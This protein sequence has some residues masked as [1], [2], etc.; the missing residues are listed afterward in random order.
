MKKLNSILLVAAIITFI[1]CL[2][3][4]VDRNKTIENSH[5]VRYIAAEGGYIDG[6]TEQLVEDGGSS[7]VVIAR[8]NSGYEFAGW[9][10]GVS[11]AGRRELYVHNNITV[12]AYFT[13]TG[14]TTDPNDPSDPSTEAPDD[15]KTYTLHYTASVGGYILAKDG[16]ISGSVLQEVTEGDN[17]MRVTAV[18]NTGYEFVRWSDGVT[19]ATRTD[20]NV[21]S[22]ITVTAEF[23]PDA[24]YKP[25][26][27]G[28]GSEENPYQIDSVRRLRNMELYHDAHYVLTADIV[29]SEAGEGGSN[30][31]PLFSDEGMFGG[32]LDGQGH[33]IVNLTVYNTETFYSGLFSCI[34]ASGSV[35]NL[36]LENASVSGT[37]YI[38][39]IAGYTL[40]AVTDCTVSGSITYLGG[41][42]YKVFAGGIAGRAEASVDGCVTDV[43]VTVED[44]R[45]ETNVGGIVGYLAYGGSQS[46]PMTL[47]H[48]GSITVTVDTSVDGN[49]ARVGG[50]IGYAN[51]SVYLSSSS[52]HDD[53]TVSARD[54][55]LG[56]LIGAGDTNLTA[57]ST[58]GSLTAKAA[59]TS[60]AGGLVG[61]GSSTVTD[62]YATGDVTS[63]GNDSRAGGLVGEG[64]TVTVTDSYATGDV[65]STGNDSRAG[66]LVG[67]GNSTIT[68]SYATGSVT[69]TSTSTGYY[70][71]RA[72]GLV[73]DGYT[74]TVRNSYSVSCVSAEDESGNVHI[75]GIAGYVDS[76]LT[77]ENAHWYGGDG[78]AAEYAVGYSNSLGIP[79]SIG[80]TRHNSVEEFHT[81]ADTLNAGREEPVWEHKG[82]NTLPTLIVRTDE[83]QQ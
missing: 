21:T 35:T 69:S 40:G 17:G 33:K 27:G 44:A 22:D 46:E 1:A 56:G 54:T 37:N 64:N 73:G 42:G 16:T 8:P 74:V 63:T 39:G 62:S 75:G 7:D 66:G 55:Y 20:S 82:E 68:D 71:S 6:E 29:L 15:K 28:D 61:N 60:Y 36:V 49:N 53:I 70:F 57:C 2:W 58:N 3:V 80:S 52:H 9:S 76:S 25:F 41:N 10:D 78:T 32:T 12:T 72:G 81:L 26:A 24:D 47:R 67:N 50:L 11:A 18:A 45:A 13:P 4:N 30:F 19:T 31:A 83:N 23:A 51:T 34:S 77:L 14:G 5:T 48:S 43:T 79:T 59:Y 38:G 65:T